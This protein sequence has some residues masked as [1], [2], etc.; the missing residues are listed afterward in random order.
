MDLDDNSK[1]SFIYQIN[2]DKERSSVGRSKAVS[3]TIDLIDNSP[4]PKLF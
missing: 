3:V 1:L 2:Y 4:R